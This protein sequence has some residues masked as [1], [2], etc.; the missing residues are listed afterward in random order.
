MPFN[1]RTLSFLME[2]RLHDSREWFKE[3]RAEFDEHVLDPLAALLM[4]I[5]PAMLEIDPGFMIDPRMGKSISRLW[6][7][8]RRQNLTSVFREYIWI[9]LVREKYVGLPGYY[10]S[11][12]PAG[13]DYGC[14]W[15]FTDSAT[16]QNIRARILEGDPLFREALEAYKN[17]SVFTLEGDK[18]KRSRHP[19]QP[20]EVRDWLDR[21]TF[22]LVS[23][24]YGTD[25]LFS[26]DLGERVI[27]DFYSIA[28]IY[29]FLA[30]AT[31]R[32]ERR[33]R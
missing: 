16:V 27:R 32:Y 24:T 5:A 2:N 31:V 21:K 25:V 33:E 29:R 4:E 1:D 28:P 10:F 9:N 30:D 22:A 8:T 13:C 7:D 3:H 6:R 11:V 23:P 15:Y 20:E 17:Q 26:P 14:G 19:D 18:L 12:S